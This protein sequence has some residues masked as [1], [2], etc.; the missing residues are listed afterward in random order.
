MTA[1]TSW[2]NL[3]KPLPFLVFLVWLFGTRAETEKNVASRQ[4]TSIGKIRNC[5]RSGRSGYH[6]SYVFSVDGEEYMGGSRS[7]TYRLLGQPV[8]IYYDSQH[9]GTTALEDFSAQSRKNRDMAYIALSISAGL[10]VIIL[11][12]ASRDSPI[13]AQA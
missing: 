12:S 13:K 1:W 11:F 8:V 3:G 5:E 10:I 2:R 6:C 9:L 4:R 7:K